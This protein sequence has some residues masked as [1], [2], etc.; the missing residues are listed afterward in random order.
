MAP[1]CEI[2]ERL[3][4]L[5]DPRLSSEE[6]S[7][8]LAHARGC[9][10][11]RLA[12]ERLAPPPF[13]EE[14]PREGTPSEGPP[15]HEVISSIEIALPDA[16][17]ND[18]APRP[19]AADAAAPPPLE[20]PPSAPSD[21]ARAAFAA[22]PPG[23]PQSGQRPP[24][25][26][27]GY[28][29][30]ERLGAGGAGVV[31]RAV[32]LSLGREVA[33]KILSPRLQDHRP[34][35]E[36]FLREAKAAARLSHPN[37]VRTYDAGFSGGRYF[38]AMELVAGESLSA[39]IER[40]GALPPADA[41]AVVADAAR[42]LGHAHES[43]IIH[44]DV[45]PDNILID[46]ATGAAKLADLGLARVDDGGGQ[47]GSL[48]TTGTVFGTPNY[49][50]PEQARDTHAVD[51]RT[52]IYSLGATFHHALYGELPFE[53][54]SVPE[55]LARVVR[56][57]LRPP[58]GAVAPPGFDDVIR[59]MT[60]PRRE[61]RYASAEE[62]LRDLADLAAGRPPRLA[63]EAAAASSESGEAA[64]AP[65][66]LRGR[67]GPL[68]R[69]ASGRF[70]AR[71]RGPPVAGAL[72]AAALLS[73][74]AGFVWRQIGTA[75][76][77]DASERG[78]TGEAAR[79]GAPAA[80]PAS[81]D[82]PGADAARPSVPLASTGAPSAGAH[83]GGA[84]G[85][86]PDAARAAPHADGALAASVSPASSPRPEGRAVP[87][88]AVDPDAPPAA[89]P[90]E[91]GSGDANASEEAAAPPATEAAPPERE[92]PAP[93]R[94]TAN[95]AL[96][97][98]REAAR[99]RA[100]EVY[101]PRRLEA[102]RLLGDLKSD[103]AAKLLAAAADDPELAPARE[104]VLRDAED[105][106]RV[107]EIERRAARALEAKAGE[108]VRL[109]TREGDFRT[110]ILKASGGTIL[111]AE[112]GELRSVFPADLADATLL[113]LADA[114]PGEPLEARAKVA[115]LVARGSDA[116]P[117]A[118]DALGDAAVAAAYREKLALIRGAAHES[119]AAALLAR[120]DRA[121]ERKKP[122]E[123]EKAYRA[124]LE[125][126][127]EAPSVVAR[128]DEVAAR[129]REIAA[130][131]ASEG[132]K[133]AADPSLAKLFK[134]Q[135]RRLADGRVEVLYDFARPDAGV[136]RADFSLVATTENRQ[137]RE[138]LERMQPAAPPPYDR[139]LAW[140]PAEGGLLGRGWDRLL[141]RGRAL[142]DV[143]VEVAA[144]PLVERNA[145]VTLCDPGGREYYALAL[146]FEM[147]RFPEFLRPQFP[148]IFA[149][150][151]PWHDRAD[152]C[153]EVAGFPEMRDRGKARQASLVA[154]RPVRIRAERTAGPK[155]ES[156]LRLEAG[157]RPAL[158]GVDD[159]APLAR[160][161]VALA[162][163]HSVVVYRSLKVVCRLDPEWA[164]AEQERIAAE[165]KRR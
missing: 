100:L 111:V 35:V 57:R 91:R 45:K 21:P 22:P 138:G 68:D 140:Q 56:E 51:P 72:V 97:A 144:T 120:A 87:V 44:R 114:A 96:A 76:A 139:A 103:A 94:E 108:Q 41:L 78:R 148:Q 8:L 83:A 137:L 113:S 7:D 11:C 162:A 102:L 39:R 122:K 34:Y 105:A 156:R 10:T 70:A 123:A 42:A 9:A 155:G 69:R 52:D 145:I 37:I 25:P 142:G 158:E 15:G 85:A 93:P 33:L 28:R 81:A 59:R 63:L 27:A 117:A 161:G 98:L 124:A 133:G 48:T 107:A 109:E 127:G 99:R 126:Y 32:Q 147:P 104:V 47:T 19:P 61:D 149:Q 112:M 153:V 13:V 141:W 163:W 29:L 106:P 90:S 12:L 62:V 26:A 134:G 17:P 79:A 14:P 157:G 5:E 77:A 74:A 119:A 60:A 38:Y 64:P 40:L 18:G 150:L 54:P 159:E 160:G 31:Y 115:L 49:M 1:A 86:P 6:R 66:D 84:P 121:Y 165:E 164:R 92:E 143:A 118:I 24:Q 20:P 73:V 152:A 89:R 67:A 110:G 136:Q 128:R 55:I 95:E 82:R 43:G 2:E 75:P 154:R 130:A 80:P 129:L 151:D 116:A 88:A 36:R 132:E 125:K 53:A 50:S 65:A 101:A 23:A 146:S 135:A 58:G 16:S 71:R 4:S 131:T 30:L 3:A 46:G